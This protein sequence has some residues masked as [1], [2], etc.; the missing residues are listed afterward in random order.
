MK[1]KQH[2]KFRLSSM[3]YDISLLKLSSAL[4]QSRTIGTVRLANSLPRSGDL[5][6]ISGY[7]ILKTNGVFAKQL[8][9]TRV[10]FVEKRRCNSI[11][12]KVLP[13]SMICA[14]AINRDSCQGDSGGE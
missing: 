4:P 10:K 12:D 6:Y 5:L 7:G 8:M 9:S 14:G 1:I 13:K 2:Q 3:A 11:F